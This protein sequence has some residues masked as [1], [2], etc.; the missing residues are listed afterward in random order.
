MPL[1]QTLYSL[2]FLFFLFLSPNAFAELVIGKVADK[3]TSEALQGVEVYWSTRVDDKE[4]TNAE[5]IFRIEKL[6]SDSSANLILEYTGKETIVLSQKDIIDFEVNVAMKAKGVQSVTASRWEQDIIEVPASIVVISRE[7]IEQNGYITLQEILENVPGLFT[8]E[9][10]SE[11]GV[12]VGIRGFWA[13]FNKSV[14]IQVNGVNML[15]ERRNDFPLFKINVPVESIDKIEIVRGPMSVIYGAGAFF[16]VVN[17]I[18]NDGRTPSRN[19][20]TSGI[21]NPLGHKQF[22]RYSANDRGLGISINAMHYEHLGFPEEW[23]S[24]TLQS[25]F[26]AAPDAVAGYPDVVNIA[27]YEGLTMNPERYSRKHQSVNLA[28][29]YEDIFASIHYAYSDIGFSFLQPGPDDRNFY[30]SSTGNY[31]IGYGKSALFNDRFDFQIKSTYMR[32]LVDAEYRY[33]SDTAFTIGENHVASFRNEFNTRWKA[34]KSDD[35]SSFA[36]D[37]F[38]GLYYN[39]NF[40]NNSYYNAPEFNLRNWY[41]GLDTNSHVHTYAGYLQADIKWDKVQLVAGGRIEKESAYE[42]LNLR[43]AGFYDT[44]TGVLLGG[45]ITDTNEFTQLRLQ[46]TKPSFGWKFIPRLA[47]IWKLHDDV[48]AENKHVLK[49]MA[50][51]GLKLANVAQNANDI[52]V[53]NYKYY[54]LPSQADDSLLYLQPE[55]TWTFET[56]YIFNKHIEENYE[57]QLDFNGFFNYLD[58]LISRELDDPGGTFVAF[59]RN[60]STI[61]SFGVEAVGSYKRFLNKGK[62]Y[63]NRKETILDESRIPRR[64]Y[65]IATGSFTA[66]RTTYLSDNKADSTISFSPPFLATLQLRGTYRIFR[67]GVMGNLVGPMRALYDDKSGSY[68]GDPADAYVRVSANIRAELPF[69]KDK[70]SSKDFDC[71]IYFNLKV[72]NLLNAQYHYPTYSNNSWASRGFLGRGRQLLFTVGFLF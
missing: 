35:Q 25:T 6:Q 48:D 10:R 54:S 23:D 57:F 19:M 44:I 11:T 5:G 66:V 46:G 4:Y 37:I 56:G 45:D 47:V 18:T 67:F 42:M 70:P 53:N 26:D 34:F 69:S 36:M 71:S 38:S 72:D 51:R 9:H 13:D 41:V 15:N 52:M 40:I 1:K 50:A 64:P 33:Y 20:I 16:G 43:N 8:T 3:E 14:M 17:I 7:E 21:S 55:N 30:K 22:F 65:I 61:G 49:F 2:L 39:N 28:V 58:G 62:S 32:S 29:N 59:S 24:L 60:A 68:L 31:Q 27:D 63:E 12:S